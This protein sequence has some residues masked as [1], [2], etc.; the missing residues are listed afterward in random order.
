MFVFTHLLS[1]LTYSSQKTDSKLLKLYAYSG[2]RQRDPIPTES[3]NLPSA[4]LSKLITSSCIWGDLVL[5]IH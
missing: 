4:E 2:I 3:S 5:Q 1:T